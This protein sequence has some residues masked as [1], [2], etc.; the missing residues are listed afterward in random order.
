MKRRM[1]IA[2][3]AL[4]LAGL[5]A[6]APPP[7]HG[8]SP[9]VVLTNPSSNGQVVTTLRDSEGFPILASVVAPA[10]LHLCTT[11][12]KRLTDN[13]YWNGLGWVLAPY[14][15][16]PIVTPVVPTPQ[17]YSVRENAGPNAANLTPGVS[18][19][20]RVECVQ[21]DGSRGEDNITVVKA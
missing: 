20:V 12:V 18:Y 11:Q 7:E 21:I 15:L 17:Y 19:L 10:G 13:H 6:A 5:V 16:S 1:R 4:V 2:A 9:T 8:G 14:S 3:G